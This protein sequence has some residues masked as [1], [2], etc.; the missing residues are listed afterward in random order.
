VDLSEHSYK[1][2]GFIKFKELFDNLSKYYFLKNDYSPWNWLFGWMV[3]WL[4]G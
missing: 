4:V 1:M 2:L 3:G